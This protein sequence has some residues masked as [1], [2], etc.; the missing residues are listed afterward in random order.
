MRTIATSNN[1][2]GIIC[3]ATA[4][5]IFSISDM[6][7]KT[8]TGDY[9]LHQVVLL[10]A[11]FAMMV[12]LGLFM[13]LEGGYRNLRSNR[14]PLHLVRGLCVV[15]ANMSF[16]FGLASMPLADA[17]AIFFCAPLLITALSVPLLGETVGLKRWIAV[18]VGF[19]GVVV[20]VRPGTDTFQVAAIGP[21]IAA[22]AYASMQILTRKL[23]ATERASTLAF[24]IQITFIFTCIVIG[25]VA[26]DGRF[27]EGIDN[28]SLLFLLRAWNA[29]PLD[30]VFLMAL[31]G[32]A[33]AF[34]G[35]LISQGY[36]MTEATTAAPFEYVTL[37][38]SV[39]WGIVVFGD[40]PDWVTI[41]GILLIAGAG[42]Y[43]FSRETVRGQAI[44]AEH[45]MPRDR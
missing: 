35:Y 5:A 8:L 6:L 29:P 40:W 19:I 25:L 43:S 28:P 2:M 33:S 11:I 18:L 34:G 15:I 13:P 14:V 17:T 42:F 10:R 20:V 4:A 41:V 27:A 39:F 32:L 12:T 21:L 36:R 9:P 44:A 16:F 22:V 37:P 26:G 30:D 31:I 3:V 38:L 7:L 45:P 1:R 23:G 24:Y